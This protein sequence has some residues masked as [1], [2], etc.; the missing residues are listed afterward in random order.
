[1]ETN[2]PQP[3][4]VATLLKLAAMNVLFADTAGGKPGVPKNCV[5]SFAPPSRDLEPADS[6]SNGRAISSHIVPLD[7]DHELGI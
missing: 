1:M 2:R 5:N 7:Y 4:E 6:G 3:P